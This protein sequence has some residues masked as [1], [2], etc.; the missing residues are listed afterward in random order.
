M[1]HPF[2][3]SLKLPGSYIGEVSI[4][5][6]SF[7][8]LGLHFFPEMTATAFISVQ[9]IH[10]HQ[11]SQL[12]KIRL[13]G[14][15]YRVRD[16]FHKYHPEFSDRCKIPFST[17]E[18]LQ[19]L[20]AVTVCISGHAAFIP[21]DLSQLFMKMIHCFCSA[22]IF[23]LA[24]AVRNHLSLLF[25]RRDDRWE[26]PLCNFVTQV[27]ADGIGNDKITICQSLHQGRCPRRLAP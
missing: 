3:F 25:Q 21:H 9:C 7:S 1:Q 10:A 26:F 17:D 19:S 13:H 22:D 14:L 24:D 15:P 2:V 6:F 18:F 5:A 11:F 12:N 8:F 20:R 23:Q 27:I 4:I 16:S